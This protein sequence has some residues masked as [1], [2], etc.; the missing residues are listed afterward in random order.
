MPSGTTTLDG[1]DAIQMPAH[2]T[3]RVSDATTKQ[4]VARVFGVVEV[5]RSRESA[6]GT[7]HPVNSEILRTG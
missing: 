5:E 6:I 7:A 2:M 1:S 4:R 3:A